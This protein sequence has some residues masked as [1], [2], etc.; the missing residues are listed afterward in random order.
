MSKS[1]NS[2]VY[3][4]A[5]LIRQFIQWKSHDIEVAPLQ[6]FD[7][8]PSRALS[9]ICSSLVERLACKTPNKEVVVD[10]MRTCQ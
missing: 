9:T 3:Q 10:P 4:G 6:P 7:E 5:D 1:Q 2:A 8:H